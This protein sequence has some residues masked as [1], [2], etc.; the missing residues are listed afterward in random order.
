MA[1]CWEVLGWEFP[2]GLALLVGSSSGTVEKNEDR[3]EWL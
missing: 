2:P 1:G 3:R